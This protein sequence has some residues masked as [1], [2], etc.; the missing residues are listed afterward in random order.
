MMQELE[1]DMDLRF[2]DLMIESADALSVLDS[3]NSQCS[4]C[5]FAAMAGMRAYV[6]D[7][8]ARIACSV[9]HAARHAAIEDRARFRLAWLPEIS[10]PQLSHL[11]RAIAYVKTLLADRRVMGV[12][13]PRHALKTV[14]RRLFA[15]LSARA[16][17]LEKICL[18]NLDTTPALAPYTLDPASRDILVSG[19]RMLPVAFPASEI[20]CW[21]DD[22]SSFAGLG[23]D[24]LESSQWFVST[25][26]LTSVGISIPSL[27]PKVV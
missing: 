10:Q 3:G 8:G 9:C 15:E 27:D 16:E 21:I 17:V 4:W 23:L 2:A 12:D 5:G 11:G 26:G 6:D 24:R 20:R 14:D 18:D 1:T 13:I 22:E 19:M 7:D 25:I